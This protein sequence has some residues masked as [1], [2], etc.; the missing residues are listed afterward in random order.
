MM[1]L[2]FFKR[3]NVCQ[4]ERVAP[5]VELAY[6]P[7]CGEL[8]ENQWYLVRCSC[9]GVKL[10]GMMKNGEIVAEKKFCHNCGVNSFVVEKVDKINFIDIRYSV[11]VKVIIKNQINSFTQSWI[12]PKM[13]LNGRRLIGTNYI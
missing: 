6:C 3:N 12:D 13:S 9:C 11:L 7:D 10:K 1:I 2:E 5:D 4:H 8:V